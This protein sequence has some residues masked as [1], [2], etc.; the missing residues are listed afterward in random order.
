MFKLNAINKRILFI[1][2]QHHPYQHKDML[3]FLREVKR[4]YLDKNDII[5]NLGDEIDGHAV[6]FHDSDHELLSA[7]DELEKAK[8]YLQGLHEIF[9]KM[10]LVDSNH[11]SLYIRRMKKHGIPIT[12]LKP[13]NEILGVGKNWSWHD[14]ILLKTKLGPVYVCHG[15]KSTYNGLNR[16]MGCSCVQGHFHGKFEVTW[17][18]TAIGDTFNMFCGC[19]IDYNSL[20]FSYGKNNV[21]K[22]ILGVGLLSKEGYPKLIKLVEDEK[23]NWIG[24]LP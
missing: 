24:K 3:K 22:P 4:K 12:V 11:G 18:R 10:Y 9:P 23:G 1:S 7:G 19:L 14:D 21:P 17:K 6:S 5:L 8:F 13:M 20:A 2:D 15:K 16:E